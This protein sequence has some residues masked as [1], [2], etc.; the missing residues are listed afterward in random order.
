MSGALRGHARSKCSTL[1]GDCGRGNYDGPTWSSS[2]SGSQVRKNTTSSDTVHPGS[3]APAT[4]L[5]PPTKQS[6]PG[7]ASLP[8]CPLPL[9]RHPRQIGANGRCRRHSPLLFTIGAKEGKEASNADRMSCALAP[10]CGE[11]IAP[12]EPRPTRGRPGHA[13]C[14]FRHPTLINIVS[15]AIEAEAIRNCL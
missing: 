14:D 1:S 9:R 10:A 3:G 12:R 11:V 2:S 5:L 6:S 7:G 13:P 15:R 4:P 8:H